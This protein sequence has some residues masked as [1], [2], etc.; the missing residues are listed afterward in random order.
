MNARHEDVPLADIPRYTWLLSR[1]PNFLASFI[2]PFR[3]VAVR[4]F[5]LAIEQR[6]ALMAALLGMVARPGQPKST[7]AVRAMATIAASR[8]KL[9]S[10][11]F[12]IWAAYCRG[13]KDLVCRGYGLRRP[14]LV[15][16]GEAIMTTATRHG[17]LQQPGRAQPTA[18]S[19]IGLIVAL[20]MVAGLIAAVV[21]VAMPFIPAR[22]NVFTGVVLLAFALGWALLAVLSTRFSD[23]PQ[24]WAAAPAMFMAVAGLVSLSGSAAVQAGFSW[25]WP[26]V[27]F[28]LVV[29][30]FLRVR[31][32]MR[33]RIGRWLLY[34]Y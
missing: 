20:S 12:A 10:V 27:L 32:D 18:K 33:S 34:P 13:T 4:R 24:R 30:M 3:E 1:Y 26:P 14:W 6:L 7:P 15:V 23:Q 19:R 25:V 31:R 8:L 9:L 11:Y 21:L 29:W 5:C 16:Q 2:R 28:G 17:D 22:E